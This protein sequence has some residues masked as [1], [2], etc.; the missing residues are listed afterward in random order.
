M[1][2]SKCKLCG[3]KATVTFIYDSGC[4]GEN[5][6]QVV[7]CSVQVCAMHRV[8]LSQYEWEKLMK[9]AE[10][11]RLWLKVKSELKGDN[12]VYLVSEDSEG[13]IGYFS[14]SIQ[15]KDHAEFFSKMLGDIPIEY[16]EEVIVT[17]QKK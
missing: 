1:E 14:N 15:A 4:P 8:N 16:Y 11:P 6:A 10:L 7:N 9:P 3:N 17:R 2:V 13:W 5:P 12:N